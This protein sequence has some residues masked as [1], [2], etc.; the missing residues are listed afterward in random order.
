MVLRPAVCLLLLCAPAFAASAEV[1]DSDIAYLAVAV[2]SRG[3]V[4][5]I[6][7]LPESPSI[8]LAPALGKTLGCT[9]A[10][11][12][13][14]SDETF[15]QLR[16]HCSESLTRRDGIIRFRMDVTFLAVPLRDLGYERLRL[17]FEH[18]NTAYQESPGGLWKKIPGLGKTVQQAEFDLE[19]KIEP[20]RFAFGYRPKDLLTTLAPLLAL[21]LLAPA[22]VLWLNGR[23]AASPA[24]PRALW[25]SYIRW[26]DWIVIGSSAA[27]ILA[28]T[29]YGPLA[30][31]FEWNHVGFIAQ[32]L[33]DLVPLALMDALCILVSHAELV[34]LHVGHWRLRDT[35]QTMGGS[36]VVVLVPLYLAAQAV[37][38][39]TMGLWVLAGCS[40]WLAVA[41]RFLLTEMIA[42]VRYRHARIL[43]AGEL[44]GRLRALAERLGVFLREVYYAPADAGPGARS[45]AVNR[46]A[47][48]L[49]QYALDVFAPAEAEAIIAHKWSYPSRRRPSV[50]FVVLTVLS[51]LAGFLI[52][53][54]AG[55][56]FLLLL[57]IAR[58]PR[59]TPTPMAAGL[60]ALA[61]SLLAARIF[62]KWIERRADTRAARLTGDP[63]TL[64][65]ALTKLAL[66]Q[67][68]PWNWSRTHAELSP[69]LSRR[70]RKIAEMPSTPQP[71]ALATPQ[72]EC[73]RPAG[74]REEAPLQEQNIFSLAFRRSILLTG[75]VGGALLILLPQFLAHAVPSS[76]WPLPIR[77]LAYAAG[78]VATVGISIFIN[79][80]AHFIGYGQMRRRLYQKLRP[81]DGALCVELSPG[82]QARVHDGFTEW[83]VGFCSLAPGMM[84][85]LG[86]RI[87]FSL[88]PR[89]VTAVRLCRIPAGWFSPD[90]IFI[91][92]QEGDRSGVFALILPPL[93]MFGS[94]QREA[95][96]L[97]HRL[98][99][100]RASGSFPP[101][102]S[103]LGPPR[104]P[105]IA[106]EPLRRHGPLFHLVRM[107]L[108]FGLGAM[109][110]NA[111][112][113]RAGSEPFLALCLM[114]PLA[115]LLRIF[116]SIRWKADPVETRELDG[117]KPIC[118]T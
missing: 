1:D 58:I 110:A 112:G 46:D 96:A 2:D 48:W 98:Q 49:S 93:R 56:V 101:S 8:R 28:Q 72:P 79:E 76:G 89:D 18:P 61:A 57:T 7:H 113:Y 27:C 45:F 77:L 75:I 82:A 92:W 3:S 63:G 33:I 26:V 59:P 15:W 67:Q 103:Q 118:R 116:P 30:A 42:A 114:P 107:P 105:V 55:V 14:T 52:A 99:E 66:L 44:H 81:Q 41:S 47:I 111:I 13:S 60:V 91:D 86:E 108:F 34:R 37:G 62:W 94:L 29:A 97:H 9:L 17:R 50:F 21:L 10:G 23:A 70:L 87:S 32:V 85:Y 11:V 88:A 104:F 16:G 95:A 22:L 69:G 25:F 12:E 53:I 78:T 6:V 71:A 51:C 4:S 106:S 5:A 24:D 64:S 31:F 90:W 65:E 39:L 36:E 40:L 109:L 19:G 68:P 84:T 83:D 38:A 80:F 54:V 20:V 73:I 43:I 115:F 35:F 102:A 74:R 100:W 117:A